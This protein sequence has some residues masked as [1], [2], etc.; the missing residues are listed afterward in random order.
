MP[1][2]RK[3]YRKLKRVMDIKKRAQCMK[4]K[5]YIPLCEKLKTNNNSLAKALSEEKQECQLL[6]SQNVAL[7]GEVQ[8]LVSACNKR[9]A[10]IIN[11]S[12]NAKEMLKVLVTITGYLT[13]TI[14]MCQEFAAST[15]ANLYTPY[16]STGRRDSHRR[17]SSKSPTKGVVK[18]M[19]SGHTITKPTINLSRVTMQDM[20]NVSNLSVI[21]EVATPPRNQETNS[22]SSPVAV[23]V[24]QH[25]YDTDRTRR[26]P[27]RLTVSSPRKENER[28]LSKRSSRHSGRMSGKHT[29]PKSGRLSGGNSTRCSNG[30]IEHIRSPTV[31]LN[32]VSKFLQNSQTINIRLLDKTRMN[33]SD[34]GSVHAGNSN[35]MNQDDSEI[36]VTIPETSLSDSSEENNEK[37]VENDNNNTKVLCKSDDKNEHKKENSTT[38]QD[39]STNYDDPLEGPSWLFN[40]IQTVPCNI[41]DEKKT[42]NINVSIDNSTSRSLVVTETSDESDDE[43]S[44]E[45]LQSSLSEPESKLKSFSESVEERSV[46]NDSVSSQD[47]NTDTGC[48]TSVLSTSKDTSQDEYKTESEPTQNLVNFITQRRGY[49]MEDEEDEDDFTLMYVRHP[50]D[51]QFD[52]NDLKFPV[53]EESTLK[54]IAPV[55]PEPEIT[56]TLRKISQI[57]P[58]PSVSDNS[59]NETVFN[60]STVNLPLLMNND[61]DNRD[62]TPLKE[63]SDPTQRKKKGKNLTRR[64]S[65]DFTDAA[66]TTNKQSS[67]TNRKSKSVGKEK[68]ATVVLQKLDNSEVKSRTPTPEELHNSSQSFNRSSFRG[69]DS[70]DSESSIASACSTHTFG[71]PRRK[72]APKNFKE[73]NLRK[74]L[75]RNC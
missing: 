26:M 16:N 33:E 20:N 72:R 43:K 31:K 68:V 71:R 1:Q 6:F 51:M 25:R 14:S 74:K 9:D 57:C 46:E 34:E 23:A 12:K 2:I 50:R 13:N 27:E 63:K 35:D 22:L 73:P 17:V 39:S 53:L 45:E 55:E 75:R 3:K 47:V 38:P 24:R 65:D 49:S 32:D 10:V 62:L 8:D 70:S 29:R 30:N 69:E 21:P 37:T 28:R 61:Y 59:I 40:N 60:H 4:Y 19:V 7:N 5:S 58:I 41:N 15:N 64:D 44:M 67:H 36:G 54:P 42:D 18:P 52:I 56:T 11:I 48:N 66:T